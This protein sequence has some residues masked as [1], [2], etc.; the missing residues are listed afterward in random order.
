MIFTLLSL[1]VSWTVESCNYL[2]LVV[3]RLNV[4]L[5]VAGLQVHIIFLKK[6][7]SNYEKKFMC[8]VTFSSVLNQM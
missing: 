8:F 6:K 7:A 2:F 4:F 5:C 1:F 3:I